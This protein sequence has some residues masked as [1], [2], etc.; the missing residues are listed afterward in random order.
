MK[1]FLKTSFLILA[2]AMLFAGC[3]NQDDGPSTN[4]KVEAED[5]ESGN[6][7]TDGDWV[8]DSVSKSEVSM[9]GYPSQPEESKM[10]I[11]M[12]VSGN[13]IEVTK[14]TYTGAD[15]QE[16]DIT[17]EMNSTYSTKEDVAD[18]SNMTD[19]E[20]LEMLDFLGIDISA[21]E[22]T[23]EYFKNA[24]DTEF[25]VTIDLKAEMTLSGYMA[26]M[27]GVQDGT[28]ITIKQYTEAN[29]KKL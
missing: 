23:V 13:E 20:A 3:K 12:T 27:S 25:R 22:P 5:F 9:P 14:A 17:S 28:K 7:L 24:D 6:W 10:H 2:A 16:Q 1:K 26:A 21:E 18:S 15:G 4:I 19:E 11:E 8:M 29:Y